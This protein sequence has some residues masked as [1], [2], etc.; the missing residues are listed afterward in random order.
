MSAFIEALLDGGAERT[1][2]QARQLALRR[3]S[4]WPAEEGEIEFDQL[5]TLKPVKT[6]TKVTPELSD[7]ECSAL[8]KACQGTEF[9]DRRDEAIVRLMIE[10][11]ARAGEV[12]DLGTADI[13]LRYQLAV[14][15]RGKGGRARTVTFGAKTA[16]ALDRYIRG[17]GVQRAGRQN[18]GGRRGSVIHVEL[19]SSRRRHAKT[20][21][22]AGRSARGVHAR[23]GVRA[24]VGAG[25]RPGRPRARSAP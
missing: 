25:C 21:A 7:D 10:T 16:L 11:G 19:W 22:Q 18:R 23:H 9:R 8:I 5:L 14:I 15:R 12:A 6:D 4:A 1:T 2:A 24:R 3:F 20:P 13:D 17:G